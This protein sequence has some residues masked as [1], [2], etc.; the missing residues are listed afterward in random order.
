MLFVEAAKPRCLFR[1]AQMRLGFLSEREEPSRVP[2]F[3]LVAL[4]GYFETL[5]SELA[6]RL[7]HPEPWLV[8]LANPNQTLVDQRLEIVKLGMQY[9]VSG[10]EGAP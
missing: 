4:A 9:L 3:G 2:S 7:E 6:D 8:G 5:R 10:F 1:S